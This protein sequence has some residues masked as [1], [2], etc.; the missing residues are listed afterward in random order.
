MKAV[1]IRK[2]T[3]KDETYVFE[4][5]LYAIKTAK[6]HNFKVVGIEDNYAALPANEIEPLCDYFLYTKD[7]YNTYFFE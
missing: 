7:N 2:N 4:D 1:T 3:K 6:K 5:A